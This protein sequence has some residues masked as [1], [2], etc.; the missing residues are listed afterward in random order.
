[1]IVVAGGSGSRMGGDT[2]KQFLPLG[3]NTVLMQSISRLSAILPGAE[4]VVV[5]SQGEMARWE[6]LKKEY[7]FAVPHKVCAGGAARYDSVQ[8]GIKSVSDEA[9]YIMVH[10]GVRPV[11]SEKMVRGV[12]AAAVEHGAAIPVV[13]VADSLRCVSGGMSEVVDREMFRAVQTPQVFR[14]DILREAYREPYSDLFTDDATVVEALGHE[15]ALTEGDPA[16]IKITTPA[17]LV[18]A[19][20][21]LK[22]LK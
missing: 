5:L 20:E 14:A 13:K 17:D 3:G 21:L 9:E 19:E 8:N 12:V 1:M 22:G 18:M 2:P 10:D 7:S 6:E 4:F 16:N 11:I 15:V